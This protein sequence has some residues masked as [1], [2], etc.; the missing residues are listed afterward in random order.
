MAP[1]AM[2]NAPEFNFVP[3]PSA[4]ELT[5][6]ISIV[7]SSER[8]PSNLKRIRLGMTILMASF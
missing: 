5:S 4:L 2:V 6:S 3:G 7:E 8:E 1:I